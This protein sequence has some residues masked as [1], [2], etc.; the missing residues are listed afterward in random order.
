[1]A[2]E[3]DGFWPD[4][5]CLRPCLTGLEDSKSPGIRDDRGESLR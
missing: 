5:I 3:A 4:S 1:M 2:V